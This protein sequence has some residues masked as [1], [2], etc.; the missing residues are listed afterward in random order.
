MIRRFFAFALVVVFLHACRTPQLANGSGE[1][2]SEVLA[3]SD[4]SVSLLNFDQEFFFGIAT[5]PAHAEDKLDDV[6][7]EFARDTKKNGVKAWQN[8]GYPE[9]RLN[10]WSDYKTEI[11][12]AKELGI[13]VFRMG[14]DWGRLVPQ[15]PIDSCKMQAQPCYSGISDKAALDH[16]KKIVSYARSQGM[17]VM[18]TLFHHSP[19]RWLSDLK[20]DRNGKTNS[21]GWTNPDAPFYFEAFSRDVVEALKAEV[22]FWVIFNEPAIFASLAYGAG[23][24]PPAE[25]MDY[26]GLF[27]VG[28]FE[29]RVL[30]AFNFMVD[31]H[32][33][34]YRL[35]KQIDTISSGDQETRRLG[36]A[37]VGVAHNVS[38]Q[39][40]RSFLG[41]RIAD[42][43]RS[44]LNYQF[45]DGVIDSLDFLGLNYYGEEVVATSGVP[46]VPDKE[47]S[48]SGRAVNPQGLYL[49]LMQFY[50]RYL[51]KRKLPVIIT[52]NGIS[53]STDILRPSYLIEHLLALGAARAEGVPIIGYIFWTLSDNWEWADGY[54]PKFGLASVD[55]STVRLRRT[56]RPSFELY[57]KIIKY[58]SLTQKQR[59][60][61]WGLVSSN[62]GKNRPFCRS[63]DGKNSLD[64]PIPR[65]IVETDWRFSLPAETS[66]P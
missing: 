38:Y 21:G 22:D 35:I 59:D 9:L 2:K 23:I 30:K 8:A 45:I 16:Y 39:T 18:M 26:L 61:A 62:F 37:F 24:W 10:F 46:P 65:A 1:S 66:K 31:A 44:T 57:K 4:N 55:R 50:E 6:W 14:V 12:L 64:E 13:T 5:A 53:D 25:G 33:R 54:C 48:E 15:A 58:R 32:K 41:Q 49:T 29:G 3:A 17:S 60:E 19:P 42:Y 27:K 51:T 28:W 40:S 34:V 43:L 20:V 36:P 7:L 63:A 47:Y 52:E 56:R 11:D